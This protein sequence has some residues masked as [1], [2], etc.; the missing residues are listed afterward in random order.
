MDIRPLNTG[1][2]LLKEAVHCLGGRHSVALGLLPLLGTF[3]RQ[4]LC[5][6]C[7]LPSPDDLSKDTTMSLVTY[8][9][10]IPNLF[11]VMNSSGNLV[12]PMAPSQNYYL[13]CI[14]SQ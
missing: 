12:E 3:V 9:P 7:H 14:G 13:K 4:M 2:Y 5:L 1:L 6:H 10:R 8:R 11:W